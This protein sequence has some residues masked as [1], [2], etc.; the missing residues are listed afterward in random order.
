MSSRCLVVSRLDRVCLG[1]G[2]CLVSEITT[3]IWPLDAC[4]TVWSDGR[5]FWD[6]ADAALWERMWPLIL[7]GL[8]K[9]II[10]STGL[11]RWELQCLHLHKTSE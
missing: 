7:V 9:G 4:L 8:V 2:P 11:S 6:V 10:N 5:S 3:D 1:G